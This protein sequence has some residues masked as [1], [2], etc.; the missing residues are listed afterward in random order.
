MRTNT[1]LSFFGTWLR[2]F[3]C[4]LFVSPCGQ[5]DLILT[6][7]PQLCSAAK[8]GLTRGH[9]F[10]MFLTERGSPGVW[11]FLLWKQNSFIMTLFSFFLCVDCL[12]TIFSGL[13]IY[14]LLSHVLTSGLPPF[15]SKPCVIEIFCHQPDIF[16]WERR[17]WRV[18]SV[19]VELVS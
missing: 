16:F 6:Q 7:Y 5:R 17:S 8:S 14:P 11:F 19:G 9:I 4:F 3:L 12:F 1:L 13:A 10:H 15:G 18:L 2:G